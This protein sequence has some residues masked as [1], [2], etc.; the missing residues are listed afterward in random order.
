M[1]GP[2][3]HQQVIEFLDRSIAL[4]GKALVSFFPLVIVVAA[5]S[6]NARNHLGRAGGPDRRHP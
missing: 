6:T 4:A 3:R 1:T 5:L 2:L